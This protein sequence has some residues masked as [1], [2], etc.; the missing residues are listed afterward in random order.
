MLFSLFKALF[1]HSSPNSLETFSQHVVA[2]SR[3][4]DCEDI[5]IKYT[6]NVTQAQ[7]LPTLRYTS[8][9]TSYD[10]T[11]TLSSSLGRRSL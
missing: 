7:F 5:Q 11:V 1:Q 4:F 3:I 10:L 6:G 8:A 2:N 9:G